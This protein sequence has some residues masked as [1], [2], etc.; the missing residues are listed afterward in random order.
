MRAF[1]TTAFVLA[2][3]PLVALA[4]A[5][6]VGGMRHRAPTRWALIVGINDYIFF[7]DEAGGDLRGAVP[8]ARAMR[9]VLI[10]RYGFPPENIRTLLDRAAT[11]DAIKAQL[12]EWLP[13][14]AQPGDLVLF[15]FAGHGSQVWDENDDEDDGLDET[16]APAD[17]RADNP[18]FDIVDEELGQWLD[19]I[20][21]D[22]VVFI[23]DNCNAGT[24]TRVAT[25]FVRLRLLRR[26]INALPQPP[27]APRRRALPDQ[28]DRIGF[29]TGSERVL[30]LA[31]TRPDQAAADAEFPGPDGGEPYYGGAFT[32]FLVRQLWTAPPTTT[33]GTVLENVTQALARARFDQVPMLNEHPLRSAPLFSVEGGAPAAARPF[34]PATLAGNDAVELAGGDALGITV[35]SVFQIGNAQAVVEAVSS[36]SARARIVSGSVGAAGPDGRLEARL[37]AFRFPDQPLRVNVAGLDTETRNALAQQV[38]G[39]PGLVLVDEA[40]NFSHLL[41]RRSADAVRI[42]GLD[43]ATRHTFPLD[44]NATNALAV[45]LQQ[46]AAAKRLADMENPAQPFAVTVGFQDGRTSF[47]IG[48]SVTFV[49]RAERGGYLTLV[50]LGTDG[51]V[52]VLFPNPW[53]P[54][55]RIPAGRTIVFPSPSMGSEIVAE[56]PPGRGIV[57]AIVTETPLDLPLAGKELTSSDVFLADRI[58]RALQDAAGRSPVAPGAVRLD[59]WATASLV[60]RVEK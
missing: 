3:V 49:A 13:S 28:I 45:A 57:R 30:E 10:Y 27:G 51:T 32:T 7:E 38:R 40:E 24:G 15:F 1:A 14:V 52:T 11:R 16:I 54:D 46:E 5:D 26:D 29:N 22:N 55:N 31:A 48:E 17:A 50:D 33:Y 9:D 42:V 36:S 37:A 59:T 4:A 53:D 60:Y 58:A 56:P 8:D 39:A 20:P 44:A 47:G 21:T 12:T 25:P 43:G 35:G 41:V 23:H 19:R 6:R 2:F 34:I 18:S